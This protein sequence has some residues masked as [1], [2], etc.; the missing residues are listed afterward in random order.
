MA[1]DTPVSPRVLRVLNLIRRLEPQERL[2]LG[3]QL[4]SLGIMSSSVEAEETL[5]KAVA[6]FQTKADHRLPSPSLDDLFINGLTY[7]E[8]FALPDDEAD[9]LWEN[10]AIE[11]PALEELPVIEVRPDARLPI[12]QKHRS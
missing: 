11:A 12:R 5:A 4:L 1:I 10:I 2:Q 6:Y 3:Q 7:H 9:A 8:Y